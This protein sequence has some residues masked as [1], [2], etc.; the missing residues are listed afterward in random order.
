MRY[1]KNRPGGRPNVSTRSQRSPRGLESGDARHQRSHADPYGHQLRAMPEDA[2]R[3]HI[4]RHSIQPIRRRNLSAHL[5]AS[6][7]RNQ[8][9]PKGRNVPV[10]RVQTTSSRRAWPKSFDQLHFSVFANK[11]A[12]LSDAALY[13]RGLDFELLVRTQVH[14][15]FEWEVTGQGD[16]HAM[17]S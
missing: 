16:T 5:P 4:V 17:L 2:F 12:S 10:P 3:R 14:Y 6:V 1:E 15:G 11:A 9:V 8:G 13:E 7:R